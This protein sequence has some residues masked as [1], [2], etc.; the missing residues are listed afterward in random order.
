MTPANR[1]R[2]FGLQARVI[3][4]FAVGAALVSGVLAVSTFFFVRRDLVA[5]HT[6]SV[7]RQTFV[8]ARLVKVELGAPSAKIGDALSSVANAD[9]VHSF[10]YRAG[11]WYSSSATVS[12]TAIPEALTKTVLHGNVA[13]LRGGSAELHLHEPRV[14][15]RLA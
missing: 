14:D 15:E 8:N 7:L 4:T 10:I 11:L 6:T 1:R 12:G 13:D 9:G 3:A 5:Q 2:R